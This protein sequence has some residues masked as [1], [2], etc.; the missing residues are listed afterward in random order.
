M[1]F[2]PLVIGSGLAGWSLLTRTRET[3]QAAFDR[4]PG[5]GTD[6][7]AFK[8]KIAS[9]E[10]SDQLLNDRQLLRVA[11]GAFGLDEDID[12]RAFI[13]K[14][15]ESDPADDESFAHRLSDKRY[16]SLAKTFG[17]AGADGPQLS[18][19]SIPGEL[20]ERLKDVAT[21]D[22]LMADPLLL[23]ST[24]ST[25]GLKEDAKNTY[26][27]R[28]VLESDPADPASFVNRLSEP[29][30]LKMVE[31]LD[32]ANRDR[33]DAGLSGFFTELKAAG[34]LSSADDLLSNDRLMT[35]TLDVFGLEPADDSFMLKVLTSDWTDETSF[36]N[37][38]S[39]KRYKALSSAFN[40]G[41]PATTETR[42]QA[43]LAAVSD[44]LPTLTKSY[45]VV[46]D[47][48]TRRATAAFFGLD[49]A[50][51]VYGTDIAKQREVFDRML[52]ADPTDPRSLVG[53]NPDKRYYAASRAFG[54]NMPD[55]TERTYPEG[56]AEEITRRYA[57]RQ[58]EIG[59]GETD[60]NMRIALSLGRELE[61]VAENDPSESAQ[62][63][64]VMSNPPLRQAF[65]T[66][67]NLPDSFGALDVDQQLVR[68]KERSQAIFGTSSI[69]DFTNPERLDDL[70]RKFLM[71][72][73]LRS[74]QPAS[75]PGSAVLAL[76]SGGGF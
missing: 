39:D 24:L 76:L 37:Q 1:S 46:Y 19:T 21:P 8:T 66:V 22:D 26:F 27:L 61:R 3:Q 51:S 17:F 75:T 42:A 62:W 69:A 35:A 68:F 56:F 63:Y 7:A 25:F 6:L 28:R 13:K 71:F 40:F 30:Y 57:D 11:L 70:T 59:V 64:S 41:G 45:Q 9:I 10:T 73:E 4:S 53:F 31:A 50:L 48:E 47:G 60:Q 49:D 55:Q 52:N 67:F 15:L 18:G 43:F 16:L 33:P 44:Q 5:I 65:E 29:K 23:N 2:T 38:L 34:T 32:F 20:K 36:V 58:F 74:V 12:N 54:F 72:S 14:V